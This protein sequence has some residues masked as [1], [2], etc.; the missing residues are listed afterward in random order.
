MIKKYL[1]NKLYLLNL[2]LGFILSLVSILLLRI[3][4]VSFITLI[5]SVTSFYLIEMWTILIGYSSF[6]K[7]SYKKKSKGIIILSTILF[8]IIIISL[9]FVFHFKFERI[10]LIYCLFLI[11]LQVT[12]FG[13]LELLISFEKT[14]PMIYQPI[15]FIIGITILIFSFYIYVFIWENTILIFLLNMMIFLKCVFTLSLGFLMLEDNKSSQ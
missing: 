4:S 6:R 1:K 7:A 9:F 5:I 14:Y 13:V 2:V 3:S 15:I 12:L 10:T 11:N 8:V